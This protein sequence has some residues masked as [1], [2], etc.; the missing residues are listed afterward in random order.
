MELTK[1]RVEE[2]KKA[3]EEQKLQAIGVVHAIE[4]AIQDC[5]FWLSELESVKEDKE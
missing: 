4:G 3:L 1:E 5:D 2:R